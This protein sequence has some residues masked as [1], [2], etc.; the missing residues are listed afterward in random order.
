MQF[1]RGT[2][3]R[4][5]A[6]SVHCHFPVSAPLDL[7]NR[8]GPRCAQTQGAISRDGYHSQE[9]RAQLWNREPK[10]PRPWASLAVTLPQN[11]RFLRLQ[12]KQPDKLLFFFLMKTIFQ[13][14]KN[15]IILDRNSKCYWTTW[16]FFTFANLPAVL[17]L[18]FP[19]EKG[20]MRREIITISDQLVWKYECAFCWARHYTNWHPM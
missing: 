10:N 20:I 16:Y 13:K 19:I 4:T 12:V 7:G 5:R 14:K 8:L 6:P 17:L 2:Q 18:F 11:G 9:L 1:S 15:Q 3:I